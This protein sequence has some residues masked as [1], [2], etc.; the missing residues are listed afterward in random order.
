MSITK[1]IKNTY[2]PNGGRTIY[3]NEFLYIYNPF[4]IKKKTKL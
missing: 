3:V 4:G 2:D 1:R